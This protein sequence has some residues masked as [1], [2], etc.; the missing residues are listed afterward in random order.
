MIP[1]VIA[2]L[3]ASSRKARGASLASRAGAMPWR[4]YVDLCARWASSSALPLLVLVVTGIHESDRQVDPGEKNWGPGDRA[5][6]GAWG[7]FQM[8]LKTARGLIE[9]FGQLATAHGKAG[10]LARAG[11]AW[12]GT[13]PG[14]VDPELNAELAAFELGRLWR[15]FGGDFTST[16]AAYN[17]GPAPV[18]AALA[19]AGQRGTNLVDE[20]PA[21]VRAYAL[22]SI[23]I[24][25]ALSER[26]AA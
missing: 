2:A 26:L 14:L 3:A 6:G 9:R 8:T 17:G 11:A 5:R 10:P 21:H 13:G 7:L 4:A 18:I 1:I 16:V 25:D 20:L 19:R 24:R 22:K 12:D 23:A 15:M